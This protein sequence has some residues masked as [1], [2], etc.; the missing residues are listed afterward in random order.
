TL[1]GGAAW[2]RLAEGQARPHAR[3]RGDR[4]RVGPRPASREALQPA[5]RGARSRGR[6][7]HARQDLQGHDRRDARMADARVPRSQDRRRRLGRAAAPRAGGRD[8]VQR[9]P[10]E[11]AVPGRPRVAPRAREALSRGQAGR[12]R[13]Y[14]RYRAR[15]PRAGDRVRT[16]DQWLDYIGQQHP[17]TIAMGLDRTKAVLKSLAISLSCPVI[18]VGGTNGKGSTCAMLEAILRAAGYRT[19][20]YSSPHLVRYNERVRI[21]SEEADDALLCDSFAA[22]EAARKDTPLT[23]FEFGTLAA[24][25]IFQ[26]L[27]IEAAVLEVG[28]GGRLD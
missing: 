21:S 2:Q 26:K 28:L 14:H 3:P 22:V 15:H 24:L 13:R 19:G 18:T 20:L 1:R 9:H 23:Y 8:R 11:H 12:G 10:E 27:K 7:R 6:L 5:P 4:R 25:W 17:Q 16:L